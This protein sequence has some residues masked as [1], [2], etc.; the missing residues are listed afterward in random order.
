MSY[1]RSKYRI[2]DS[3]IERDLEA[4]ATFGITDLKM[5][6]YFDINKEINVVGEVFADKPLKKPFHLICALYDKDGD[7][8]EFSSNDFFGGLEGTI[9]IEE[10]FFFNGFPFTFSF[11]ERKNVNKI[12]VVPTERF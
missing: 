3:M 8:I 10:P 9:T 4:E 11:W 1:K 5:Y 7:I 2:D 12:K 6:V